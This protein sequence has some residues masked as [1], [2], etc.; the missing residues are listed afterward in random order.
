[1]DAV[2]TPVAACIADRRLARAAELLQD[3]THR[4]RSVTSS[5]ARVGLPDASHFSRV[6]KS[7]F[8]VTPKARRARA[9]TRTSCSERD[10]ALERRRATVS[11]QGRHQRLSSLTMSVGFLGDSALRA[12]RT[13]AL[14]LMARA[15]R[16]N[17][18][19]NHR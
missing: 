19:A 6:F 1:V 9:A 11:R 17:E 14:V 13:R 12:W 8:G 4:E 5:V 10:I 3:P 2:G 15:S 16:S 7:R 18:G